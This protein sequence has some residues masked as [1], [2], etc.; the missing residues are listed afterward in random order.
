[1]SKHKAQN[2]KLKSFVFNFACLPA[3]QGFGICFGALNFV[4]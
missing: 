1:M 4:I 2:S 3:W